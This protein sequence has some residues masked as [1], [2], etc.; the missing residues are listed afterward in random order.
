MLDVIT[1][2]EAIRMIIG[3]ETA[4]PE[5]ERI[6]L[7]EALDRVLSEDV[8]SPEELPAFSRST[9]DGFAVKASDTF[10][11]SESLPAMLRLTAE[12]AMGEDSL[13]SLQSEC[14]MR[15]PTGGQ[16]PEGADACVMLEH[17]TEAGDGFIYVEK[18]AAVGENVNRKGDDCELSEIVA[19]AGQKLD[20]G[21]I[22]LMAAVGVREITVLRPP[23]VG[24]ISTGDE[25]IP[26]GEKPVGSQIRDIN[27]LVLKN[28]VIKTGGDPEIY[29][30]VPDEYELLRDTM[31]KAASEC[32]LV[33]ISGGTSAGEK[34]NVSKVILEE[35]TLRFHGLALKPG[36]PTMY[37]RIG[38]TPVL[39][40]PGHPMAAYFTYLLLAEPLI[41]KLG[42]ID[43][44]RYKCE[45]IL[46]ENVS[47]NH[48][49]EEILPVMILGD[50]AIPI[51]AKSG[52]ISAVAIADGYIRVDRDTE[53]LQRGSRVKV[54]LLEK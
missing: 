20:A 47:S 35:G 26:Y 30:I 33:L 38:G 48:G 43:K 50:Q 13:R 22:A 32:S 53:G 18:P 12:I 27:S 49:R 40:L 36:K 31:T 51:H 9:V 11:C 44:D 42:G 25:L 2:D 19:R 17:V 29:P 16:L 54:T 37:G 6:P 14:C 24:I 1:L 3:D 46:S 41:L 7:G 4:V 34:D 15:I 45:Y 21:V 10:G 23:K 5:T 28:L 39:G 8:L 52:I